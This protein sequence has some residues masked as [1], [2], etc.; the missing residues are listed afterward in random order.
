MDAIMDAIFMN[1]KINK[2]SDP[3]RLTLNLEDKK[4]LKRRDQ[5]LSTN[6]HGKI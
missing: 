1:S 2:T 6:I 5:I 4:N 3:Y